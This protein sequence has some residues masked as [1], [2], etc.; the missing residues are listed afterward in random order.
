M[1]GDYQVIKDKLVELVNIYGFPFI[2]KITKMMS[3]R[4]YHERTHNYVD[5]KLNDLMRKLTIYQLQLE[6]EAAK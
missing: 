6:S 5:E 4:E 3:M 2:E 1:L